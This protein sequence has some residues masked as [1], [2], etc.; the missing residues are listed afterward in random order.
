M[1]VVERDGQTFVSVKVVGTFDRTGLPNP[2]V[3]R[4]PGQPRQQ[5]RSAR[6]FC[7]ARHGND[8]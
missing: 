2:L 1:E 8:P 7:L 3:R 6:R 4:E 5:N